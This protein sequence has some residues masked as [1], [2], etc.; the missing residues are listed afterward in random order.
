MR[1]VV[2]RKSATTVVLHPGRQTAS[3]RALD[4]ELVFEIS[5]RPQR[6]A[7]WRAGYVRDGERVYEVAEEDVARIWPRHELAAAALDKAMEVVCDL[8]RPSSIT[9]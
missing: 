6:E 4:Y 9:L 5:D 7:L 8:R 3:V 1:P 2:V